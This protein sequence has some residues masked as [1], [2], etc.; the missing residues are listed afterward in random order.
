MS[1]N[2]DPAN[3]RSQDGATKS[4]QALPEPEQ[5]Q[6][7]LGLTAQRQVDRSGQQVTPGRMP[8]FRR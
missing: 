6:D 5:D 7:R 4:Q 3:S 1:N 2:K 8:L